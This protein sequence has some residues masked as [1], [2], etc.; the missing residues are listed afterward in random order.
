MDKSRPVTTQHAP[1]QAKQQQAQDKLT[2]A[3]MPFDPEAT[4][5][6]GDEEANHAHHQRPMEQ[7][8]G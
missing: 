8:G 2:Q 6:T 1:Q 5:V 4:D 7:T 3:V